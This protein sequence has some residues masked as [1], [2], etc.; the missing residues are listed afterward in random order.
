MAQKTYSARVKW[1]RDT[2]ANWTS[3]DPILL[4]GEIVIV[5]T[6]SG[7]TRFKIGDGTKKYSQLPFEDE[8]VRS[9]ISDKV[10][11]VSGKELSSNDYTDAEKEKLAGIATGANKYTHPSYTPRNSGLYKLTVDSTGHI[12]AASAVT[13]ADITALGIPGSDTNTTYSAFKGATSSAAGGSGLVPAPSQG[14]SNRYLRSDG[15]WQ[16]PPDTNTTY[17]VA[18]A[19]TNGLMSSSDKSKLDG[20]ASGANKTTVDS[21]LSSSSTNPVQNKVINSALAGKAA[22]NHTHEE[23][24]KVVTPETIPNNSDLNDYSIPGTYAARNASASATIANSPV[25]SAGFLLYVITAYSETITSATVIQVVVDCGGNSMIYTRRGIG[26]EWTEWQRLARKSDITLSGLGIT[27]TA[28]ELNYVDGVTSKIQTQLN[29]KAA[30]SHSHSSATASAAGFM[31]ASDKGKL[32]GIATGANKYT[33]PTS[34]GNKHIPSGGS[35]GQILRWS[36]DGTAVWGSDNNTTYSNFKG[37]TTSAAGG[38]GLVPAPAAGSATRYLRSDGTWQVPPNTTYG[39]ATT[40]ANGLMSSSDKTKLNGIASGANKYTHPSYTA[41][42]S[43]LY[44]MTVDSSGHVSAVSAVTKADITAL[45]IPGS[46]TNTTYSVATTSANG[47][48]SSS[49]KTKLNGIANG[50][51]KYVHPTTSGN[52]HIPTGGA[53]NQILQWSSAGTAAWAYK[54]EY[55]SN[56]GGEY[57]TGMKWIDGKEIYGQAFTGT[58]LPSGGSL[59]VGNIEDMGALIRVDGYVQRE[60]GGFYPIMFPYYNNLNNQIS[61]SIGNDTGVYVYKGNAWKIRGYAFV[62]FYTKTSEW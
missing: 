28:T 30:S 41:R 40:S 2:S 6:S 31:S 61:V 15:T 17:S 1:K 45:G 48:M 5:D 59:V 3:N 26:D 34:S 12:S 16:V 53:T 32:D 58:T 4:D 50:A 21:A 37:A 7:E 42:S 60:T 22:S 14:A 8:A 19:S 13:K 33:H 62:V 49:D 27:A 44:K 29:G 46:D 10:D 25:S 57:A 47:L 18:T 20:I 55:P 39:V 24:L 35:S 38:S 52:K 9:L 56:W 43:G 51:N 23:Y 36:S 11:K 54:F